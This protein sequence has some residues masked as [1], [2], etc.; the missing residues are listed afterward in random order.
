MKR[1]KRAG[2]PAAFVAID[3]D[4]SEAGAPEIPDAAVPADER[5]IAAAGDRR[6]RRALASLAPGYRMI[7]VLREIEGLSTREVAAVTGY[8]EANVKQRLRRARLM[9]RSRLEDA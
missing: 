6:L 8:S 3:A 4:R 1:R 2:E 9:L 5:L 7:L